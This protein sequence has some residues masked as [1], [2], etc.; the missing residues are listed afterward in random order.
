MA[1]LRLRVKTIID[2]KFV[3]RVRKVKKTATVQDVKQQLQ[4]FFGHITTLK[5]VDN[6]LA[7]VPSVAASISDFSVK[8]SCQLYCT[9]E[10]S[11][12]D[13]RRLNLN[14]VRAIID[15]VIKLQ[16][17][18]LVMSIQSQLLDIDNLR[19][20]KK[21]YD[22][23]IS[24]FIEKP[25]SPEEAEILTMLSDYYVI[26]ENNARAKC[27]VFICYNTSDR[28]GAN[29]EVKHLCDAFT[30]VGFVTNICEWASFHELSEWIINSIEEVKDTCSLLFCCMM[31]HGFLGHLTGTD[32]SYGAI[33][34]LLHLFHSNLLRSTPLVNLMIFFG[35]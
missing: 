19:Y 30:K 14:K 34:E 3:V 33:N 24:S 20:K 26:A 17:K 5:F 12:V 8:G 10:S 21:E 32:G 22:D 2:N 1:T 28:E 9:C 25:L 15:F 13:I 11:A 31:S 4:K 35:Y 23:V 16:C 18:K 27:H 6:N 7:I 29:E